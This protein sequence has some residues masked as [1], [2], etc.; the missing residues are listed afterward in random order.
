MLHKKLTIHFNSPKSCEF[1]ILSA[2]KGL[3]LCDFRRPQN[4]KLG[5]LIIARVIQGL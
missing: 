1:V 3:L 4:D 5:L 2:A